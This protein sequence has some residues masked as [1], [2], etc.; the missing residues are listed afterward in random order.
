MSLYWLISYLELFYSL[1]FRLFILSTFECFIDFFSHFSAISS[2]VICSN[3]W[4]D[5][6]KPVPMATQWCN[7][8]P[9]FGEK[10]AKWASQ[11]NGSPTTLLNLVMLP[12]V[13]QS[14]ECMFQTVHAGFTYQT[15]SS[16]H[17]IQCS[18]NIKIQR[19]ALSSSFTAVKYCACRCHLWLN[20]S[21]GHIN[22]LQPA[23][24]F[25]KL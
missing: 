20:R 22:I 18:T 24:Y 12:P 7:W 16:S 13:G 9:H 6:R 21:C 17:R 19:G 8:D 15:Q 25:V 10:G 14:K 2:R 1:V 23:V 5:I 4:W 11:V 3:Y